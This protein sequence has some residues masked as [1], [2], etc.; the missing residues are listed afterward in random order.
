MGRHGIWIHYEM[1]FWILISLGGIFLVQF[2]IRHVGIQSQT[3][4]CLLLHERL[5]IFS[6]EIY[7]LLDCAYDWSSI[8]QQ[9]S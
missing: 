4:Y 2:V 7:T 6:L 3:D 9:W 1:L 5:I 8:G